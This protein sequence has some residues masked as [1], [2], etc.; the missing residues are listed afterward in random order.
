MTTPPL[1]FCLFQLLFFFLLLN[2]SISCTINAVGIFLGILH[3]PSSDGFHFGHGLFA[4]L[5]YIAVKG[6]KTAL[7]EEMSGMNG[8]S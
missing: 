3:Q 6:Q 2:K 8:T 5:F 7:R 4:L 1:S